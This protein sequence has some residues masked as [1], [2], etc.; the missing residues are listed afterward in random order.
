MGYLTSGKRE[1]FK[2]STHDSVRHGQN[3]KMEKYTDSNQL[4]ASFFVQ[5]MIWLKTR[6]KLTNLGNGLK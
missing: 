1:A 3:E 2:G 6:G 4:L 5:K